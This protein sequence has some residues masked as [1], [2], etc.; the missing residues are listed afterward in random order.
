MAG[1]SKT[2][3]IQKLGIKPG[4]RV[5]LLHMPDSVLRELGPLPVGITMLKEPAAESDY[6]HLFAEKESDLRETMP[7]LK[8]ALNKNGLLWI[9]WRKGRVNTDLSENVVREL[10]LKNGLVDV[11]VCAIDETWSGLKLVYRLKDR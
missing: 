3:L 8:E 1:Y 9:S 10:A 4:M 11:K 6:I 2:P 5:A 7:R